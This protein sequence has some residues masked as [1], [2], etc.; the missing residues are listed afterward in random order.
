MVYEGLGKDENSVLCKSELYKKLKSE[1][2]V[3]TSM[4]EAV[5]S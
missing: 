1:S 4:E 5:A 3:F 2:K